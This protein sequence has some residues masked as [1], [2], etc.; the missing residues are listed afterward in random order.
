MGVEGSK[1]LYLITALLMAPVEL[2]LAAARST[3]HERA[4]VE[5]LLRATTGVANLSRGETVLAS[6]WVRHKS[7]VILMRCLPSH[8]KVQSEMLAIRGQKTG[9]MS[10]SVRADNKWHAGVYI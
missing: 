5:A 10:E 8:R 6:A 7:F 2:Q 4:P 1:E 9:H 3:F